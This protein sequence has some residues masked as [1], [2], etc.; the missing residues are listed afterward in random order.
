[1]AGNIYKSMIQN[2]PYGYA[3]LKIICDDEERLC[4]I[5]II[6][7]NNSFEVLTGLESSRIIKKMD[8]EVFSN[9]LQ[10]DFGWAKSFTNIGINGGE[11]EF[12]CFFEPT[13]HWF[14][15]RI[16][17][18]EKFCIVIQISC[19]SPE[20]EIKK[21]INFIDILFKQSLS[22]ISIMILDHP[23]K[24][25]EWIDKEKLMDYIFDHHKIAKANK[26]FLEQYNFTEDEA[27]GLTPKTLFKHDVLQGRRMF[28]RL[29]E[30]GF[31]HTYISEKRRN[32]SLIWILGDY[33]C[34]YDK[35]GRIIGSFAIQ[36]D[37]TDMKMEED[38]IRV[39]EEKYRLLAEGTL[40]VIWVYNLMQSKFT[41]MSPSIR[42]LT[43][44]TEEEAMKLNVEDFVKSEHVDIINK[45]IEETM[46]YFMMNPQLPCHHIE[47]VQLL[48]KN[49]EMI[50]AEIS[51][52]YRY[53]S[54]NEIEVVGVSRNIEER[55]KS[56]EKIIYLSYRDQL[57]GLYNRRF[58]EEELRRLDVERNLP[59]T[60][61]ISDVN[62]LKF[63][64]DVF[65]HVTGDKLLKLLA[66]TLRQQCRGDDIIARVGGDEFSILLPKTCQHQAEKIV[67]RINQA[68]SKIKIDQSVLSVSFGLKT[69]EN[70][71]EDLDK[72]YK[73][74]D[75]F[76]YRQKLLGWDNYEKEVIEHIKV[77][78]YE[79]DEVERLHG[80]RVSFTCKNIGMAMGLSSREIDKLS[81][82]G[83]LHDIGKIG[84]DRDILKRPRKANKDEWDQIRRHPEVGYKILNSLKDFSEIAECVLC[85]HERPDGKGYPKGISDDEIPLFSK[86]I[87]IA[88]AYDAMTKNHIYKETLNIPDV[89]KEFKLCAGAQFDANIAKVFVEK[90]L[91][92]K[93]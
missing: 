41:Y 73:Q 13:N 10:F 7:A 53:N 24:W 32:G 23:I 77:N 78:L 16:F 11:D 45:R 89:I 1:M 33:T 17:S 38:K 74:A 4:D 50:W 88:D 64:N 30:Q 35:Q 21:H 76:M 87:S 90:V 67:A 27:I 83:L 48:C 61:V 63:A 3:F 43:G 19:I 62:G 25:D 29:F 58:F 47:E 69:K 49:G 65:G 36:I 57:T 15:V 59:I 60:I 79:N 12:N 14:N 68:I 75:D 84:I 2:S 34:L 42:Q 40:D 31:L 20:L 51:G 52:R 71:E 9:I 91:G 44:Y 93:W 8:T 92:E 66:E 37:I 82:A 18:P 81:L 86:I 72:I 39:S 85:H 70:K 6:E 56:E 55:K 54:D 5:E 28:A 46:S 22:A 80:E 26:A